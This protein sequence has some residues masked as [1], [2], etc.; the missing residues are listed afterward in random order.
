MIINSVYT[1][2]TLPSGDRDSIMMN[3]L[4]TTKINQIEDLGGDLGKRSY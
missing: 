4:V 2:R 1:S 3:Q